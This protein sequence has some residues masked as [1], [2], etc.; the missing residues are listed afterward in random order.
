MDKPTKGKQ[1]MNF[2]D[3]ADKI[4]EGDKFTPPLLTYRQCLSKAASL[5]DP[6]GYLSVL[7]QNYHGSRIHDY[8]KV[9]EYSTEK[10]PK[11][12]CQYDCRDRREP[13]S[14]CR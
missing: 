14:S 1:V 6:N 8:R 2:L 11:S 13:M 5:W 3:K 10:G 4:E 7:S 9:S 12:A